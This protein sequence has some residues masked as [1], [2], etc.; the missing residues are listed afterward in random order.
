[1]RTTPE[2][3]ALIADIGGTNARFALIDTAHRIV[4]SETLAVKK[5]VSIDLAITVFLRNANYQTPKIFA[6]ALACPVFPDIIELTN[7]HWRLDK[8]KI[9]QD[10][11][12]EK[13]LVINDFAALSYAVPG[14]SNTQVRQIGGRQQQGN[15]A[16]LGPGTGLGVSGVV[17][18]NGQHSVIEGEGGHVSF[19]PANALEARLLQHIW[20][21]HKRV[22]S[23][24]LLQGKGLLLIYQSL[25]EIDQTAVVFDSPEQVS[26]HAINDTCGYCQQALQVYCA[27]LG[28][29]A[30]DLVLTLGALGGAYIGGGIIR[31]FEDFFLQSE[32]RSRFENKGRFCNYMA[33][34]PAYIIIAEVPAFDGIIQA[35][36]Q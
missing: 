1:M 32:F 29:F 22:S 20:K 25:C 35:L 10:F 6:L 27:M 19:A 13:L 12:L 15:M 4:H 8:N 31:N 2:I 30:G 16:V 36:D 5:Y 11:Q 34:I 28:S 33:D 9:T 21:K 24:R 7:S 26:H 14:L 18:R 17:V 23:E 3:K